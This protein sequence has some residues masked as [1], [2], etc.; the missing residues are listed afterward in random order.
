VKKKRE[1][2]D[3][4]QPGVICGAVTGTEITNRE[5]HAILYTHNGK[6]EACFRQDHGTWH[7]FG[8]KQSLSHTHILQYPPPPHTYSRAFLTHTQMLAISSS[9]FLKITCFIFQFCHH[10]LF[11]TTRYFSYF[12]LFGSDNSFKQRPSPLAH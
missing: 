4:K 12:L 8:F 2:N 3:S 9:F 7:F 1:V 6:D 10:C 11:V 5:Y